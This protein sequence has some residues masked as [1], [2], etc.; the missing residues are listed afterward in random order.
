LILQFPGFETWERGIPG[1]ISVACKPVMNNFVP[2]PNVGQEQYF[3]AWCISG[4]VAG[5]C[6]V[7]EPGL[8]PVL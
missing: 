7:P 3:Q 6:F 2:I 5:V 1:L 4:P 8:M